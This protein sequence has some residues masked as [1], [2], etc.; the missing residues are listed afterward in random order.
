VIVLRYFEDLKI[1]EIA[2]VM[3]ENIN[4]VKTRLYEGLRKLRIKMSDEIL[5]EVK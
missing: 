4:T 2:E 1:D 5:E 3:N